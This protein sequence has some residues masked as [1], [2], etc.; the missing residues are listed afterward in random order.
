MA[1]TRIAPGAAAVVAV[2][3]CLGLLA[4]APE[5]A[6]AAGPGLKANFE[7]GSLD[8]FE[9]GPGWHAEIVE[10]AHRGHGALRLTL[11]SPVGAAGPAVRASVGSVPGGAWFLT[12]WM[13]GATDRRAAGRAGDATSAPVTLDGTWQAFGVT[14]RSA[15]ARNL[16]AEIVPDGTWTVGESLVIDTVRVSA[17]TPRRVTVQPG[18]RVIEVDGTPFTVKGPNYNYSRIGSDP[19]VGGWAVDP[20]LCQSDATLL[21]SAGVNTIRIWGSYPADPPEQNRIACL[22]AF[23]ANGIGVLW[24]IR[25]PGL[26]HDPTRSDPV[27]FQELFAADIRAYVD[28]YAWH[29][30]TLFWSVNNE[31]EVNSTPE[32]QKLWF[33]TK[34]GERGMLDVLAEQILEA[35]PAHLVGTAISDRCWEGYGTMLNANVPHLQY[36]GLNLYP[37]PPENLSTKTCG[38]VPFYEKLNE[39]PR[40]KFLNEFGVDRY[41]C[42]PGTRTKTNP[43]NPSSPSWIFTCRPGSGEDQASAADWV[44]RIWDTISPQFATPANPSG[45][46]SGGLQFKWSDDWWGTLAGF[47]PVQT[48]HTHEVSGVVGGGVMGPID[49]VQNG[50]WIGIVHAAD[51]GVTTP[52]VSTLVLDELATRWRGPGPVLTDVALQPLPGCGAR[53][54]WTTPEPATSELNAGVRELV[55]NANGEIFSDSTRFRRV[56]SEAALV[57]QHEVELTGLVSGVEHHIVPRSFAADGDGATVAPLSLQC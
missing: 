9:P 37:N 14:T 27:L 10:D 1:K 4:H 21:R 47:D 6:S 43:T 53:V 33:G 11:V 3:L 29:P 36:W 16:T 56:A 8:G 24:L 34:N 30:A 41:H 51:E 42:L 57:T 2:V 23:A 54:T 20:A 44:G 39:D 35:D 55:A 32:G 17:A 5:T 25:G 26:Q 52:R 15:E 50:E 31:V 13:R 40:P 12:G 45:A 19:F 28:D 38:G 18:T 22:D 48:N 49:R 7:A 46:L